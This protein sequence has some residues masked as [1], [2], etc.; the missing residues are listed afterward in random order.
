[1]CTVIAKYLDR[2]GWILA[3]NR[4]QDYV[5]D[6]NFTYSSERNVGEI[7]VLD[8][9]DIGYKEGMNEKGLTIITTSLTPKL[10]EETNGSDGKTIYRALKF[11]SPKEAADLVVREKLTGFI[12]ITDG[13]ELVLV[14]AARD[15]NGDGQY[16]SSMR[17]IPR[18][19]TIVRTNH[20]IDLKWAGF[21]YGID[22]K[23]DERRASS[24]S[25][26][27]IAQKVATTIKDPMQ[28][29]DAL[30]VKRTAD[31][32]MNV[33]RVENKP[34]QMRTIMQWCLIPSQREVLVRPVQS[35]IIFKVDHHPIKVRILDNQ[36]LKK[37][38]DGRIKN[39]T[40]VE[41]DPKNGEIKTVVQ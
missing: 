7:M 29:L 19:D 27:K 18:T 39:F 41:D 32:Q 11:K 40:K 17:V 16:Q 38:Y 2:L 30:A 12:F 10:S 4:D 3:K 1:M 13:K 36:S 6:T 5:S 21:Q 23:Q 33:F 15:D 9:K 37:T 28:A 26:M 24:E 34:R 22:E 14:E 25:R 31:L 35:K 20:G 8:D